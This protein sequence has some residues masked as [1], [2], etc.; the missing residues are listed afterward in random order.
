MEQG[1]QQNDQHNKD[2]ESGDEDQ[3][4]LARAHTCHVPSPLRPRD[5]RNVKGAGTAVII[6]A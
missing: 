1:L 6:A 2:D 3:A 5:E 4:K